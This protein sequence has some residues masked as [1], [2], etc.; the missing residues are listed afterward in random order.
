VTLIFS[1]FPFSFCSQS[2]FSK[3][4]QIETGL[5]YQALQG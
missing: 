1:A 4:L 3:L 2:C 5:T